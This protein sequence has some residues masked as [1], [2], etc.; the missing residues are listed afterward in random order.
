MPS[1]GKAWEVTFVN[2]PANIVSVWGFCSSFDTKALGNYFY[3][4][5][6]PRQVFKLGQMTRA[7]TSFSDPSII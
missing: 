5:V 1:V 7:F 6:T 4:T 3:S 2:G